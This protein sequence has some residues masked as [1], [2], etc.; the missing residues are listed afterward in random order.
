MV[1]PIK[2]DKQN[3]LKVFMLQVLS[4]HKVA[5]NFKKINEKW[6]KTFERIKQNHIMSY[7]C[8]YLD[9]K[10]VRYKKEGN[11]KRKRM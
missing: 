2:F 11:S 9:S 4:Q 5:F 3:N 6:I 10:R 8:I 7:H 1:E